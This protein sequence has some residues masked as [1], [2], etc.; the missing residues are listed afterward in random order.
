[1]RQS[2]SGKVYYQL[3]NVVDNCYIN[4]EKSILL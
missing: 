2:Y 3:F 1:M 4:S